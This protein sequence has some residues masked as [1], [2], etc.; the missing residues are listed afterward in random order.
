[1]EMQ[2]QCLFQ[3]TSLSS[4]SRVYKS[5]TLEPLNADLPTETAQSILGKLATASFCVSRCF[6]AAKN[7]KSLE[8]SAQLRKRLVTV[9]ALRQSGSAF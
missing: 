5:R 8:C 2:P 3:Q 9:E 1:M 7:K 4:R 6:H